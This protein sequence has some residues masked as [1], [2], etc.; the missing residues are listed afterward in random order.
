MFK[1]LCQSTQPSPLAFVARAE[2]QRYEIF[3]PHSVEIEDVGDALCLDPAELGAGNAM[4][5][6]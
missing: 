3:L 1:V 2:R 4:I 5:C 6:P